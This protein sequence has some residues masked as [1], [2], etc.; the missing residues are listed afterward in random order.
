[1]KALVLSRR[2]HNIYCDAVHCCLCNETPLVPLCADVLRR[3]GELPTVLQGEQSLPDVREQ[4]VPNR[5]DP[6]RRNR[7]QGL[8]Y[9]RQAVPGNVPGGRG[10]WV[11]SQY[12]LNIIPFSVDRFRALGFWTAHVS[13]ALRVSHVLLL[14]CGGPPSMTPWLAKKLSRLGRHLNMLAP[15]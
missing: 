2:T 4:H 11:P 7:L 12:A 15:P 3:R 1:V 10:G 14:I 13:W 8:L 9:G 5:A 6:L